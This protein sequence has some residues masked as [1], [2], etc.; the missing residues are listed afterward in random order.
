MFGSG[1]LIR[2]AGSLTVAIQ[3]LTGRWYIVCVLTTQQ[4]IPWPPLPSFISCSQWALLCRNEFSGGGGGG[5]I[6]LVATETTSYNYFN[7]VV[8]FP[9][10]AVRDF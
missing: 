7:V 2:K 8:K 3:A 6:S 10:Y 1:A 5:V 4:V 9:L